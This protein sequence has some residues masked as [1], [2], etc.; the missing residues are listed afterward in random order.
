MKSIIKTIAL[1]LACVPALTFTSCLNDD[2]TDYE[3]YTPE[4]KAAYMKQMDG[5][6]SGI[7]RFYNDTLKTTTKVDSINTTAFFR[8]ADST[9]VIS[10]ISPRVFSKLIKGDRYETLRQALDQQP[11][12]SLTMKAIFYDVAK[13][14]AVFYGAYPMEKTFDLYYDD[15][16]HKVS[17]YFYNYLN[18]NGLWYNKETE[19]AA[20]I[21]EIWID[22]S[23]TKTFSISPTYVDSDCVLSFYGKYVG[24]F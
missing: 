24:A 8:S 9:V 5:S 3:D 14:G 12:Q 11:M 17:F 22:N 21:T 18:N 7:L 13:S 16:T 4:Q 15:A 1:L 19:L 20:Y 10:G 6:Y 23:R 2:E